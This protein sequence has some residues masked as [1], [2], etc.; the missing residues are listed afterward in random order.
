MYFFIYLHST[1]MA[2]RVHV[3][4]HELN[5]INNARNDKQ[6]CNSIIDEGGIG[7]VH[8]I[9][10]CVHNVLEGN[11]PVNERDYKRLEKHKHCLRKLV[12]KKTSDRERKHLIQEG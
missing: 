8:C 6:K 4:S 12:K 3:Y 7:L 11:I 1:I 9:C 10:D 2:H 5:A